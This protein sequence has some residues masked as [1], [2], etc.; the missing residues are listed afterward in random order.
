MWEMLCKTIFRWKD[1]YKRQALNYGSGWYWREDTAVIVSVPKLE[2]T[3]IHVVYKEQQYQND[4]VI[5][6]KILERK[7]RLRFNFEEGTFSKTNET[8]HGK[9]GWKME[10][11]GF[12]AVSYTHLET[13]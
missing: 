3:E 11:T 10:N 2:K 7:P 6:A 4:E 1:V 13:M 9:R 8:F 5:P 12:Y